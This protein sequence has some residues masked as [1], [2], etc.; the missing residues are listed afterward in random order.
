MSYTSKY[1][2]IDEYKCKCGECGTCQISDNALYMF[3]RIRELYNK[4]MIVTSGC[5]CLA[6]NLKVGGSK[7]SAHV[8]DKRGLCYALD[9]KCENSV[10]RF[11]LIKIALSLGCVRIG[12]AKTFVHLD[13]APELSQNVFWVY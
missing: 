11:R 2:R 3:D 1:F 6:H 9:I 4:P 13:F 8:P 5:R 10:D 7:S 12:V